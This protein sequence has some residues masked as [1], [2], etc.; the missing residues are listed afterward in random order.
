[1][2]RFLTYIPDD[3]RQV[4]EEL[5][6]YNAP[7]GKSSTNG[8]W[9]LY[10]FSNCD[11]HRIVTVNSGLVEFEMKAGMSQKWFDD[12][13]VE[14]T[15]PVVQKNLPPSPPNA[16]FYLALGRDIIPPGFQITIIEEL[17]KFIANAVLP[18]FERFF[19][20]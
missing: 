4:I 9:I 8:L 5:Q 14:I 6:P 15:I 12:T 3:A 10:S 2:E 11:K 19:P 13:A 18:R 7:D 1:V 20:E 17:H 16:K